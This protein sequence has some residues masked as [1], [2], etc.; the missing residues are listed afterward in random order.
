MG[1]FDPEVLDSAIIA[2]PLKRR[3]EQGPDEAHHV[4]FDLNLNFP[5]GREAARSRVIELIQQASTGSAD[6]ESAN[7]S[8]G[9]GSSQYVYATL[10][11]EVIKEIVRLD[12]E[13]AS[14]G[15]VLHRAIFHV[16]PDFEIKAF[17]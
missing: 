13:G 8:S 11:G 14:E 4:V 17:S 3:L 12:R 5:E 9:T 2:L 1:S 16:W 15:S 6:R 7:W 10:T